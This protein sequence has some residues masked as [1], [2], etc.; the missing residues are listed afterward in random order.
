LI[1]PRGI[2]RRWRD[3][4]NG[5]VLGTCNKNEAVTRCNGVD[6]EWKRS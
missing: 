4:I 1:A 3:N 6:F 5:R 2:C